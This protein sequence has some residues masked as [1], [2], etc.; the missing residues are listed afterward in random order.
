MATQ[1]DVVARIVSNLSLTDPDLDTAIGSVTRK[2]IDAVAESIADSYTDDHLLNYQFDIDSKIGA[3]LD[4]FV[5]LFGMSRIAAKRATGTV[6]FYRGAEDANRRAAIPINTQISS[7][8]TPQVFVQTVTAGFLE[9]NQVSVEVPVQAVVGGI[10]GNVGAGLL[11]R[12]STPVAGILAVTNIDPLTGGQPPETDNELRERWKRTVFRSLAGTEAMYLGLALNAEGVYAANV[13]GATK[14]H[15][16]QVQIKA[17]V[18]QSV[19]DDVAYVFPDSAQLAVSLDGGQLLLR[20]YDYRFNTATR[21]PQIEMI[22]TAYAT[23]Q[24]NSETG[25][26]LTAPTEGAIF[27]L[28]YEYA[29][30]DSRNLPA[31]GITNRVDIWCAGTVAEAASQ[32]VIFTTDTRFSVAKGSAYYFRKFLRQSGNRPKIDNIFVPLAFGPIINIPATLTVA[33]KTYHR[34]TDYFAVH[35]DSPNGYAANS[36]CGLEWDASNLP[37]AVRPVF[38]VGINDDYVFNSVPRTVQAG[39]D[40][41]RIGGVDALA[42]AAKLQYL[43]FNLVVSYDRNR[44]PLQINSALSDAISNFLSTLSFDSTIQASDVLQVA[45]GVTGV[46][47]VRFLHGTDWA[48]YNPATPNL[49]GVGIQRVVNGMVVRSYVDEQ[50]YPFDVTFGDAELAV[51]ESLRGDLLGP[52]GNQISGFPAVRAQN[53]FYTTGLALALGG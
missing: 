14:T 18:G 11:T 43:R 34:D 4:D 8:S 41:W 26:L 36:L 1:S 10:T 22:S 16:E 20:D 45:H 38:I 52:D 42:H 23:G 32:A 12:Q 46:D 35:D 7:L 28:S 31:Q 33:G 37:S 39:I 2:I 50:G 9:L 48:S 53:T 15:I 17:G 25:E 13:V 49:Y 5:Q 3:D 27:E 29:P 47:N 24:T 44:D 19:I 40:R 30:Q 6:V 21:P 51:F